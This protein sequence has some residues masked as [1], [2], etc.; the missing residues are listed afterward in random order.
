MGDLGPATI[1][2]AVAIYLFISLLAITFIPR[3]ISPAT[4][5]STNEERG[6]ALDLQNKIR[7]TVIQIAAGFGFV[8]SIFMAVNAQE[9]S[10][11]DLKAKYDRESAELFIKATE[12][13]TPEGLYALAY[14]ARRDGLHPVPKTPS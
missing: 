1:W 13:K 8:F 3:A 2:T 14:I 12:S 6:Q 10:N 7:Q 9:S 11:R 5:Q 4:P